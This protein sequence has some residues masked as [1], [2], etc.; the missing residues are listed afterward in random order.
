[1]PNRHFIG[2]YS[3]AKLH[4]GSHHVNWMYPY[5]IDDIRSRSMGG[6]AWAKNY[7]EM[8]K[9][10]AIKRHWKTLPKTDRAILAAKAIDIDHENNGIDFEAERKQQQTV[11]ID[12]LQP[13]DE[14]MAKYEP[15]LQFLLQYPN[16]IEELG[17]Q[18][19][20]D[21]VTQF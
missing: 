20:E 7:G 5:E 13:T 19:K 11:N 21:F 6:Q 4:D 17:G 1:E 12:V 16:P 10:T 2:A 14:V 18:P 3:V 8:A 9:K 15:M